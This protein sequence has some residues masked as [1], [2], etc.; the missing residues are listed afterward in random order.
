MSQCLYN[1]YVYYYSELSIAVESTSI[2]FNDK[3]LGILGKSCISSKLLTAIS[4][5]KLSVIKK[6][7]KTKIYVTAGK[8][9]IYL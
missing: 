9:Q 8:Y 4:A 1:Y 7:Q 6:K 2:F 3:Q 5:I